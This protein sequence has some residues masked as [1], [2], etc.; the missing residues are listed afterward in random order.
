VAQVKRPRP[1]S[2]QAGDQRRPLRRESLRRIS[3]P[4][5]CRRQTQAARASARG[6]HTF[7]D[8][9]GRGHRVVVDIHASLHGRNG[10]CKTS[11]RA[12]QPPT[13]PMPVP[14]PEPTMMA[15]APTPTMMSQLSCTV[16]ENQG[17]RV[18]GAV[19]PGKQSQPPEEPDRGQVYETD[20][21]EKGAQ[22]SRSRSRGFWHGTRPRDPDPAGAQP[23]RPGTA[24]FSRYPYAPGVPAWNT[25]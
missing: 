23:P 17:L 1:R 4:P 21:H 5:A 7:S 18:L 2:L 13:P 11:F 14:A 22:S 25:G 12:H 3:C 19:A 8:P 20:D 6:R 16:P 15:P 24:G 9:A 10:V